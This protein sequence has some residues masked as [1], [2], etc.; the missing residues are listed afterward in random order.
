[1]IGGSLALPCH[2]SEPILIFSSYYLPDQTVQTLFRL[3]QRRLRHSCV[4]TIN[5]VSHSFDRYH[6]PDDDD[7]RKT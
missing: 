2:V 7:A 5:L 4:S 1:M 3:G 6:P